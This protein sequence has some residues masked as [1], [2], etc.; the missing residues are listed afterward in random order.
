MGYNDEYNVY[1]SKPRHTTSSSFGRLLLRLRLIWLSVL[2][3]FTSSVVHLP[4]KQ[5]AAA[6]PVGSGAAKG[7]TGRSYLR[8]ACCTAADVAAA[9]DRMRQAAEDFACV[10]LVIVGATL[11]RLGEGRPKPTI[12]QQ[13]AQ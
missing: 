7:Q 9:V 6:W 8:E 11:T 12:E 13:M 4:A 3:L 5:A 10:A 1:H 2:S